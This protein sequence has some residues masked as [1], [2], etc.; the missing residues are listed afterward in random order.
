[1][2]SLLHLLETQSK[3][4]YVYICWRVCVLD[5]E[6]KISVNGIH[7]LAVGNRSATWCH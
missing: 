4:S 6:V 1:M 3:Y 2:F 5:T 7:I